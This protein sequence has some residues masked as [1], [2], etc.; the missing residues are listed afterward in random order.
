MA[1]RRI[2]D[3]TLMARLQ[4]SV[5]GIDWAAGLV[6]PWEHEQPGGQWSAHQHLFHLR[7]TEIHVFQPRIRRMIEEDAPVFADWDE[8]E[9][10]RQHYEPAGDIQALA[11]AVMAEREKT[12]ELLKPL[13]PEQWRRTG[14]WPS[15]E[16]DIAWAAER[17][18]AHALEHFVTLLNLHQ[19][20]DRF[21]ARRWFE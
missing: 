9:F 11:E 8:N 3:P 15:G 6:A 17:A 16:A 13:V 7:A 12:V 14:H 4:L 18:V 21:Q 2:P 5:K 1:E 19:H 20:F 10:L